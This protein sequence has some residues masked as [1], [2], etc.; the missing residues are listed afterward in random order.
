MPSA[1]IS[2]I[3]ATSADAYA[4]LLIVALLSALCV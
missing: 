4:E 3:S 2:L 1:V